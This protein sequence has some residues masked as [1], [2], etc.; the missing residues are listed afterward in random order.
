M[1]IDLNS[2][3]AGK[4]TTTVHQRPQ[5]QTTKSAESNALATVNN[6]ELAGKMKAVQ[7]KTELVEIARHAYR[8]EMQTLP[9]DIAAML[10]DEDVRLDVTGFFDI[11]QLNLDV[12]P[13]DDELP[14]IEV[15]AAVN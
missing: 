13:I 2:A 3:K 11:G 14:A 6:F 15:L 4:Q 9:N 5:Q 10:A 12:A 8:D 1:A 7:R